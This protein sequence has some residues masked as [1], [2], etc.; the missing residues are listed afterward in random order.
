MRDKLNKFF[1]FFRLV[2]KLLPNA[3]ILWF[4]LSRCLCKQIAARP[5][6]YYA[7]QRHAVIQLN[8]KWPD[9][10]ISRSTDLKKKMLQ[11]A[12][13]ERQSCTEQRQLRSERKPDMHVLTG[14]YESCTY[15]ENHHSVTWAVVGCLKLSK[16]VLNFF[17]FSAVCKLRR[18]EAK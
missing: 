10:I 8:P 6:S 12:M 9:S 4:P 7:R 13:K 5:N 2:G 3:L 14:Q 11:C 1:P 15:S 18:E 16:A 17:F